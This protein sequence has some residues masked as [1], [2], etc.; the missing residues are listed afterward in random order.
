MA[1]TS[2]QNELLRLLAKNR[3][4]NPESYVA[5]GLALNH[6]LGTPRLS[7]DIDIFHDSREAM[8]RSWDADWATLKAAGYTM[9]SIRELNF[10]MEAEVE[11][12]GQRMEIQWGTDS[13]YRLFPLQPD[14]VVGFTL[15]P[16]DLVANKLTAL[17][18]RAGRDASFHQV[19]D[20]EEGRWNIR[21]DRSR[22]NEAIRRCELMENR[23]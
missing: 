21:P 11:R 23:V 5:G 12:D 16:L 17:V 22:R 6:T 8:L 1:L 9:K 2:F 4:D 18:G 10:F 7:R 20:G 19:R 13:A 14:P 3:I 15:H